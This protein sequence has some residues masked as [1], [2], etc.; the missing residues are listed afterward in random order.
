MQL[1]YFCRVY[2]G[3]LYIWQ[4]I[5]VSILFQRPVFFLL[6]FLIAPMWSTGPQPKTCAIV[7]FC[8]AVFGSMHSSAYSVLTLIKCSTG[9]AV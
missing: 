7:Q 8:S 2:V 6:L 9:D 3:C 5:Y 4:A 1:S